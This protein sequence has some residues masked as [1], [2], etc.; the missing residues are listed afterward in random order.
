[1]NPL[2]KEELFSLETYSEKREE[3]KAQVLSE[4]KNRR[5]DENHI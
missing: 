5:V 4:K 2:I 3:F 1:M